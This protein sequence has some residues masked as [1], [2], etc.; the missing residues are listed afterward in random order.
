MKYSKNNKPIVCMQT[1]SRCYKLTRKMT[2]RG[3][4]FHSTGANNP[5]LKRY[6]QPTEGVSNY[7]ELISLI[8][9]NTSNNDW[10]H[11]SRDAGL[12]AWIG[13]IADG[14]V[15]TVQ[16]MPWDFRPW[17]CGSGS[18]G[19]CNDGW[20]QF[21]ICED[22][23]SD[24]NYFNQVYNEAV[25]LTA[26]L[27]KLHSLD[28]NGKVTIS[29]VDIP[30][31]T[32][33]ADSCKIGFGSNHGDINH[34]FPKYGKSMKTVRD[35]VAKL[36]SVSINEENT[37]VVT[38][39]SELYRVRKTWSD[40]SSQIGAFEVLDNAKKACKGG[41]SVF[42][43]NGNVVYTVKSESKTIPTLA[44]SSPNLKKGSKGTQVKYLQQDLNY[45]LNSSL[46]VDRSFGSKTESALKSFQSKY[47]LVADGIYG[48]KSKAKM[49]TLLK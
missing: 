2:I 31:L 13:K 15:T 32:C 37:G 5:N 44:S 8:G 22:D 17:G 49:S 14:T 33:H 7:D 4:L 6:V 26:Y 34:W 3:I 47:S 43:S 9:K 27:C 10:N 38:N 16:T 48:S 21:E 18:K 45:V 25:E 29:G 1:N 28:P 30:V 19:S 39:S 12:N 40:A 24:E 36:L 35:D 20:I 46:V 42:D 23:L 11:I 41:Y